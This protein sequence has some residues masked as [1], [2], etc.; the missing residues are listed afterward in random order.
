MFCEKCGKEI[1]RTSNAQKYCSDCKIIVSRTYSKKYSENNPEK[2]SDRLKKYRK[3]NKDKE[4]SYRRNN[5]EKINTKSKKYRDNNKEK[6]NLYEVNRRIETPFIKIRQYISASIN[7][8][9]KK[10]GLSKNNKSILD[11]LPYT[12]E[13]LKQHIEHQFEPWMSWNNQGIYNPKAW[14]DDDTSTWAWQLDHIVPHSKFSY[15]SMGDDGFKKCWALDNLRPYS[16]KQNILDGA[17]NGL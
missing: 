2:V 8:F 13:Q 3:N 7:S 17:R 12:I 14:K 9:L 10:N 11:F 6:R 4:L 15:T 1:I 16:A 5:K